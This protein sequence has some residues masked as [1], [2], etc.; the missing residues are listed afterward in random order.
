METALSIIKNYEVPGE[1]ERNSELFKC[2]PQ[3]TIKP[4]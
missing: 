4:F 2:I 3:K 1:D